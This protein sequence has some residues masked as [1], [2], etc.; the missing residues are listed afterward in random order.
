MPLFFARP[1]FCARSK[2]SGCAASSGYALRNSDTHPIC[3]ALIRGGAWPQPFISTMRARG[4]RRRSGSLRKDHSDNRRRMKRID[5][6][7]N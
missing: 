5:Y 6:C 4:L 7:P 2:V 3:S 1:G